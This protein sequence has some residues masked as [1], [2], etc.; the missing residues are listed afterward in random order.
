MREIALISLGSNDLSFW[1]SSLETVQAA[2]SHLAVLATGEVTA[3][4]FYRTSAFPAGSGPDF[5]NAAAVFETELSASELLAALHRI[6]AEAGRERVR[7]WGQRTLDLDLVAL[8]QAVLPDAQ[9]YA[10]WRDLPLAAQMEQAPAELILPH[11][12]MQDRAF[13][14]VPLAEIAPDWVHPVLGATVRALCDAL[15]AGQRDGVV[16]L[17]H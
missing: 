6:E 9:T 16:P 1:G 11:P 5:V 2:L 12:R 10:A 3:S 17:A 14:L 8:G 7:R 15:P 4:R 13:V